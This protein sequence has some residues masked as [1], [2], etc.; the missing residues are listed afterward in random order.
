MTEARGGK[1]LAWGRLGAAVLLAGLAVVSR[2]AFRSEQMILVSALG[3]TALGAAGWL[4]REHR[5]Y[6]ALLLVLDLGWISTAVWGASRAEAGVG[7]LFAL[8]AFAAGLC[9]GGGL[10]VAISLASGLAL[11]ATIMGVPDLAIPPGWVWGQGLLVLALGAASN[12]TRILLAAR[13]TALARAS[14]ALEKMRLDT[15]TI[16]QNLESG[17]VSVDGEGHIVHVNKRAEETL[18]IRAAEIRGVPLE[19]GLPVGADR[20]IET[21]RRALDTGRRDLRREIEIERH[22]VEIPLGISTTVLRGPD[23]GTSGVV[24]LFQDLTEVRRQEILDRKRDRLAAVGELAAGIAH[25]IRNSVL[26]ISGS[27]ELLSQELDLRPEQA[28]LFQVVAKETENIERFVSDLLRYSR[29]YEIQP[30]PVDLEELAG[31]AAEIAGLSG[32]RVQVE[33]RAPAAW[34]DADQLSQ[35]LRNLVQNAGDAA[36]ETGH[37]VVRVGEGPTGVWIE[38]EDDGPGVRPQ[39]RARIFEP[40]FTNKPGGTG[41]G[42]PLVSRIVE[43]HEGQL[44]LLESETGGARFRM[45]L[46]KAAAQPGVAS[47]AA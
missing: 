27:M 33:G 7:L 37:I 40:F 20:L 14:E 44:E 25:E 34:G 19:A 6:I 39:D 22:G 13:E 45:T 12:R 21:V 4:V 10:A 36:G 5:R 42:L 28:K 43:E 3:A 38:V 16:V 23:G 41:L 15:D 8:V 31:E 46:A 29:N 2:D 1:W 30:T 47:H 32:T 18:G 17:V 11:V 35:A 26:P 24:A 9:V